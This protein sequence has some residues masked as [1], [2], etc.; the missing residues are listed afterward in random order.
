MTEIA[1]ETDRLWLRPWRDDDREPFAALNADPD[2]MEF[3]PARL[4]RVESDAMVDRIERTWAERG[5]GLFAVEVRSSGA[6]AGFV[7]LWP[8]T[9]DAPFTP[10]IEV[11]WRLAREH[12]GYGY[13][14]EAA[15]AVL[16]DGFERLQLDEVVSFT[17][18]INQR[19]QRVMQ[20]L[21]MTHDPADDFDHPA[22]PEGHRLRRHVLYRLGAPFGEPWQ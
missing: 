7:G 11:G 3:L 20:R 14:T 18:V 21:G 19:S 15:D 22:L 5:L 4:T 1:L 2:V 8:A 16:A 9:F 10:A 12:W 17:A 13:A 6:F